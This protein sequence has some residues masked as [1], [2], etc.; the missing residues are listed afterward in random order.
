MLE[1]IR[2][3]ATTVYRLVQF[4]KTVPTLT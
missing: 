4:H 2:S 1:T 3:F